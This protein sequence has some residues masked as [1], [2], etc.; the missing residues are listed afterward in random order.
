[1]KKFLLTTT[2]ASIFFLANIGAAAAAA[3]FIPPFEGQQRIVSK[4]EAY[5][6]GGVGISERQQMQEMTKD[7][8]LKLVFD[9]KHGD[10]LSAVAVK[11]VDARGRVLINAVSQGP[12]F[13]AELPAASYQVI[14]TFD[15]HSF[16][17]HVTLT[18][19]AQTLI[20]SWSV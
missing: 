7:C 14:A 18:R 19:K 5:Y 16:T 12:L 2:M 3:A 11:I 6:S 1:M 8:N 20:L 15:N 10:Y 9:T 4:A 17:R 13:S